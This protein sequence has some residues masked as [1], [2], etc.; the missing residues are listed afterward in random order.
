[1]LNSHF[2]WM[3]VNCVCWW[4]FA[5]HFSDFVYCAV[6]LYV[7]AAPDVESADSVVVSRVSESRHDRACVAVV[8]ECK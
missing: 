4:L 8:G 3:R 2:W 7:C 6:S 1:M 5:V